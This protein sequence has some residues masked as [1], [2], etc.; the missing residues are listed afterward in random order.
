MS[1]DRLKKVTD[2]YRCDLETFIRRCEKSG[3][4]CIDDGDGYIYLEL[5]GVIISSAKVR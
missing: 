5:D 2:V 1:I 3:I 4:D